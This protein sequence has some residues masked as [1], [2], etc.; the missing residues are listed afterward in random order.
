M[1]VVVRSRLAEGVE[2]VE[3]DDPGRYNALTAGSF[4]LGSIVAPVVAGLFIDR[5]LAAGFIGTLLVGL[6]VLV[7][8]VRRVES[9]ITPEVN[10]IRSADVEPQPAPTVPAPGA[11]EPVSSAA[12]ATAPPH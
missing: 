11:P 2:L 3:L 8:M 7:L 1:S 9:Q 4:Q 12:T 10:G 6:G 5:D